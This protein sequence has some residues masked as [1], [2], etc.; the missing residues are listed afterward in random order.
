M[1][2]HTLRKDFKELDC[3]YDKLIPDERCR[4]ILETILDQVIE[5]F[6]EETKDGVYTF[7]KSSLY[8]KLDGIIPRPTVDK[9]I[10]HLTGEEKRKGKRMVTNKENNLLVARAKGQGGEIK[11]Y[12][13][14]IRLVDNR[15][16]TRRIRE[17]EEDKTLLWSFIERY[18][19]FLDAYLRYLRSRYYS[20][21][22][23]T[24]EREVINENLMKSIAIKCPGCHQTEVIPTYYIDRAMFVAISY[25]CL[26]CSFSFT[27]ERSFK[28]F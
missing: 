19:T 23:N 13:L 9:H 27:L 15:L 14:D 11:I 24:Q 2:N 6:F 16:N 10:L 1:S 25:K 20:G 21:P 22:Y 4:F 28:L 12:D 17:V 26:N 5:D 7:K 3:E 8:N 18:S